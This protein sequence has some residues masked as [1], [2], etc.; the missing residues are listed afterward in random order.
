MGGQIMEDIKLLKD[1][2]EALRRRVG[3][4]KQTER[5]MLQ[6]HGLET[7]LQ[8]ASQE[9]PAIET[10]I[11]AIKEE[12]ADLSGQQEGIINRALNEFVLRMQKCL[13]HGMPSIKIN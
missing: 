8:K 4:L 1:R 13:P 7:Q 12:L 2:V 9:S 3:Q 10:D 5:I 6:A 11:Q